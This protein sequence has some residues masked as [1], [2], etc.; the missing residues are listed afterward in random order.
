M[1]GHYLHL[2]NTHLQANYYPSFHQYKKCINSRMHQLIEL[3]EFVREKTDNMDAKDRIM[4]VGDFN[5]SSRNFNNVLRDHFIEKAKVDEG[6]K[7][8]FE[9]G[10]DC[11]EEYRVMKRILTCDDVFTIKDYKDHISDDE[12]GPSTFG[13][14]KILQDGSRSP[15]ETTL[16][17]VHDL[18]S[19]QSLDYIF[20]FISR[21]KDKLNVLN[22]Q[23]FNSKEVLCT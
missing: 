21:F 5:I 13:G 18:M 20:E 4:V 1:H 23:V 17:N 3:S 16:T 11:V 7:V 12:G 14:Y 19:E 15:I 22:L 9:D 8:F 2:F 10:F 6:F